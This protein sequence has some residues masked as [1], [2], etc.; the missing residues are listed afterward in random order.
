M[1]YFQLI[2]SLMQFYTS[3]EFA[4][5]AV[6]AKNEFFELAGI[7]DEQSNQFDMKMAQFTD[8]YLFSR[9]M[10]SFDG[11]AIK[12]F[13]EKR[14]ARVT[15]EDASY[16]RNMANNRYSLFE[17]KK[18]KGNDLYVRD[19]FSHYKLVIKDSPVTFGF[20]P[21]EYFQARLIPHEDS[22]VFSTAFCFHPPESNKFIEAEVKRVRK[23]PD[24]EQAQARELLLLRIFKMRNK[25]DQYKHVGIQNIYSNESRLR[26]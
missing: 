16:Y 7:F 15:E 11:P 6:Q 26:V 10:N 3:G 12:H 23:L 5:E 18:L 14:P 17:F 20:T 25:F 19:L 13:V 24:N 21:E 4:P 8:W 22:F 1:K 2:D 9:K